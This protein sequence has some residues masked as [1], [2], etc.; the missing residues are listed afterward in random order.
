MAQNAV[1]EQNG[2]QLLVGH[3]QQQYRW[4]LFKALIG[5]CTDIALI[6]IAGIVH[7]LHQC[8][9]LLQASFVT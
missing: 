6:N 1:R 5:K 2:I 7:A 9:F 3:M 8:I 4:P